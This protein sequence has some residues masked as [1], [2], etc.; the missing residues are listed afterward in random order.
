MSKQW[1]ALESNPIVLNNYLE[2]L[3]LDIS[4]YCINDVL[5]TEEW[6][7]EMVIKPI[8]AIIFLYPVK[9]YTDEYMKNEN[10]KI[11]QSG[12]IISENI[13]YMKQT[14]G[15]ACGTIALLHAIGIDMCVCYT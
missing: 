2:K 15:N 4:I 9:N 13:F 7:I 6:A 3:G 10:E 11:N 12:Q 5:S 1:Y 14:I 8:I